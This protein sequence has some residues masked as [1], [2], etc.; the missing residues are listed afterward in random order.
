MLEHLE[1]LEYEEINF[2]AWKISGE[3]EIEKYEKV[4]ERTGQL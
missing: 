2:Q 4:L 1:N 3:M